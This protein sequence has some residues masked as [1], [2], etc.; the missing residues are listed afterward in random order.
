MKDA[1]KLKITAIVKPKEDAKNAII[2]SALGYTRALTEYIID[3]S[4]NSDIVKAQESNKNVN[5]LN[6]MDFSP[7]SDEDKIKDTKTY[8]QNLG[9][10][11]KAKFFK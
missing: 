1:L 2:S 4:N 5:V 8:L 10:S 7:S 3:K 6:G 9:I 11:D